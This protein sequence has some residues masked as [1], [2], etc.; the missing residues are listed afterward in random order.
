MASWVDRVLLLR[1]ALAKAGRSVLLIDPEDTYGSEGASFTL[2]A[3]RQAA[4]GVQDVSLTAEA[5]SSLAAAGSQAAHSCSLH[6]GGQE[7][8]AAPAAA[9]TA[10]SGPQL[11]PGVLTV[12]LPR[13]QLPLHGVQGYA[14][15]SE[16][17]AKQAPGSYV[18]DLQ[19]KVR[20]S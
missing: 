3:L 2:E 16:A 10:S 17:Q 1:S 5:A 13:F 8:A 20:P 19:P 18:L 12:P 15:P 4:L 7:Q 11:E 6:A 14:L 9:G